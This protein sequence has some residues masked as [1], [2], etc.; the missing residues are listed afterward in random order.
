MKFGAALKNTE[1]AVLMGHAGSWLCAGVPVTPSPL[2]SSGI[3]EQPP[4][5]VSCSVSCNSFRQNVP[6]GTTEP[7]G[8]IRVRQS[9]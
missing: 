6:L 5:P 2:Q 8:P 3:A 9:W 7:S 4:S 1:A